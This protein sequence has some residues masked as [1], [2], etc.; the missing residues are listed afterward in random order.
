MKNKFILILFGFICIM[1]CK[2]KDT[3]PYY[4]DAS[5]TPVWDRHELKS[6][7]QVPDFSFVDQNDKT[8][9]QKDLDGKIY[10]ANFF[11]TTC[12]SVC[13]KMTKNLLKVQAA[14]PDNNEIA[15][16]SHTVTPWIDSVSRLKS[17][18]KKY[19]LDD[20]WHLVTGDKAMIYQL[21]RQSYFAE[22]EPGYDKD[23]SAFLHTEHI[24]L[25]DKD[26]H[27]R[28]IYNGTLELEI[29]RLISDIKLLL[30]E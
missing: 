2:N 9:T 23:S 22:E 30:K 27:I 13:P 11:F 19:N 29:D 24:L 1:G 8:I 26:K 20:R 6:L 10:I 16:I 4:N 12:G 5:F 3:L 14:F 28:G 18:S 15:F 25:I 17:Y 21:A 7:H